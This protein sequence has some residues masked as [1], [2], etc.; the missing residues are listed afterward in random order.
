ME[1]TSVDPAS[2]GRPVEDAGRRAVYQ[3]LIDGRWARGRRESIAF[4]VYTLDLDE[5][6]GDVYVAAGIGIALVER[7]YGVRLVERSQ[8]HRLEPTDVVVGM[9]PT[10]E[11]AD[12]GD[13]WTVAWVRNET[14]RWV[15]QAHL[16]AYDQVL[17]SSRLAARRLRLAA[18]RVDGVLPIG[19]DTDLFTRPTDDEPRTDCAVTTA[20]F[21]GSVR[22]AHRALMELP[23]DADVAM[24]GHADRAPAELLRWHRPS[25]PYFAIPEIYRRAK[26]VIDDMNRTTVGYGSVNS[27]FFEAAACGA[28]P[29]VNGTLG[30]I[31]LGF[32][33]IPRY[34]DSVE[35]AQRLRE[36]RA[37]PEGTAALARRVGAQVRSEHSWHVRADQ[38]ERLLAAGRAAKRASSPPKKPV[39]FF[40]DHSSAEPFQRMLYSRLGTVGGHAVPIHDL[41]AHLSLR[42]Q[43]GNP[44]VVH[45]HGT[46]PIVRGAA[47]PYRARQL[48]DD[49]TERLRV[50]KRAG[51]R[52]V[53]TV[54]D[55]HPLDA[56][57]RRAGTQ[58]AE[59]LGREADAVHVLSES[60]ADAFD[61]RSLPDRDR[62]TVVEHASYVGQYPHWISR[63]GARARLR[64]MPEEKVLLT[65]AD[66]PQQEQ[67]L[68][69]IDVFNR[70]AERDLALRLLVLR[71][72]DPDENGPDENGTAQLRDACDRS[73][74]VIAHF[75]TLA[76]D[77]LQVWLGAADLVVL[78]CVPPID[79]APAALARSFGLPTLVARA[80][81]KS[82]PSD[83]RAA[84]FALVADRESAARARTSARLAA[85]SYV[86]SDM[87]AKFAAFIAPLL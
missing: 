65:L 80:D 11:P 73:P 77:H 59:F 50:F 52:V 86:A 29:L 47:G 2:F 17:A 79:P 23:D 78:P 15:R 48:V 34:R 46:A 30:A 32:E 13:A 8:W 44:G 63:E 57:H 45:L 33:G 10:F 25:V 53:W 54:R 20:H 70:L 85:E 69:L 37:D 9:L 7:G 14:D 56:P 31:G 39:H 22:D 49:F 61:A 66:A 75:G 68:R 4:C 51:G 43:T 26:I 27:R 12:A 1:V 83:L 72:G 76:D 87:A 38:F 3:D 71:R 36:L 35:L 19:V 6:R 16:P 67:T 60:A 40:P 82:L 58:L 64:I 5:G 41:S 24:F 81:E 55:A 21:W 28:L 62:V 42:A 74:R 18:S 84:V